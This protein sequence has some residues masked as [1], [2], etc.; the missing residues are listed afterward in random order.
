MPKAQDPKGSQQ[1]TQAMESLEAIVNRFRSEQLPLEESLT[2]FEQGI[3]HV[4]TCQSQLNQ[5][6]GKVE[7]LVKELQEGMPVSSAT[8]AFNP[9]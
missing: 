9:E 5:A 1:F 3:S 8:E 6:K 2:L 7:L 4:H